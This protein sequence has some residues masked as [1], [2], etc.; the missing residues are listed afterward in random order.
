MGLRPRIREFVRVSDRF[1]SVRAR[2]KDG[3]C[4]I[5]AAVDVGNGLD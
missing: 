1:G 5:A 2:E 4:K 3:N